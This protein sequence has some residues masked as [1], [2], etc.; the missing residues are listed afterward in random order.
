MFSMSCFYKCYPTLC[1]VVICYQ[2]IVDVLILAEQTNK[3]YHRKLLFQA[4]GSY[5]T[6]VK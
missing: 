1:N 6:H 5:A 4:Y 2:L 3:A